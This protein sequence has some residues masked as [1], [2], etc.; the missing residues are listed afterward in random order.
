MSKPN[1]HIRMMDLSNQI[2]ED[3]RREERRKRHRIDRRRQL[4][5]AV[6]TGKSM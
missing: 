2:K 6:V 3:R 1:I 4:A 5:V